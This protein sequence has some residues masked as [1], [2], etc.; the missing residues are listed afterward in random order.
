MSFREPINRQ[1]IPFPS[2][3]YNTGSDNLSEDYCNSD[4]SGLLVVIDMTA[5]AGGGKTVTFTIQGKD[6]ASQKYYDILASSAI[7]S[8]GTTVLRIHPSLTGSANAIAKDFVP[9]QW[10]VKAT[11]SATGNFVYSVGACTIA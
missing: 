3:T 7:S 10:R 9:N 4:G 6:P 1:S 5:V 11:H 8:T 2:A